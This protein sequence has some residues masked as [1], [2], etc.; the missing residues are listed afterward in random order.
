MRIPGWCEKYALP[1]T[2]EVKD[3]YW[4]L[5]KDFS[6]GESFE[7][8]FA[9]PVT[10]VFSSVPSLAGEAALCRG[11]LV[12]CVELP[13]SSELSPFELA[14]TPESSFEMFPLDPL[15]PGCLGIRFTAKRLHRPGRLY[16]EA[17]PRVTDITAE[18]IPC[19]FRQNREKS[20]MTIFMPYL[21]R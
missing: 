15:F 1:E 18:A 9:M 19:A 8:D 3:S 13:F 11:P 2:G 6:A 14:L 21:P 10:P 20:E 17:P 7:F 16:T 4:H 5:E 12:Y